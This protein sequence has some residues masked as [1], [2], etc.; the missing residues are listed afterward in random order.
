MAPHAMNHGM[1]PPP[2]PP[3]TS[4]AILT[5]HSPATGEFHTTPFPPQYIPLPTPLPSQPSPTVRRVT[6]PATVRVAGTVTV[7][8]PGDEAF[9]LSLYPP[10]FGRDAPSALVGILEV[11]GG[12]SGAGHGP[13][14][15]AGLGAGS[16]LELGL[17][18]GHAA[19]SRSTAS[20]GVCGDGKDEPAGECASSGCG[21]QK[22]ARPFKSPAG[23]IKYLAGEIK[24]RE[25]ELKMEEQLLKAEERQV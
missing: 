23:E 11:P 7:D 21:E 20:C 1:P 8:G 22:K 16:R 13:S 15:G 12:S 17:G 19:N 6:T 18:P 24:A 9:L 2:N 3:S 14:A 10:G 4:L 25:R 5:R